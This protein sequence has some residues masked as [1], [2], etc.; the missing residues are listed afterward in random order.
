MLKQKLLLSQKGKAVKD[1]EK[2]QGS[3]A[4]ILSVGQITTE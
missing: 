3:P 2:N 4:C 1:K